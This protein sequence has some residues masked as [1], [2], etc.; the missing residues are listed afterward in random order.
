VVLLNVSS[1]ALRGRVSPRDPIERP[2]LWKSEGTVRLEA[3]TN[4]GADGNDR[5]G[6]TFFNTANDAA[7][8]TTFFGNIGPRT[9]TATWQVRTLGGT[10]TPNPDASANLSGILGET[11][12]TLGRSAQSPESCTG[13]G[14][15]FPFWPFVQL[16][17]TLPSLTTEQLDL[18]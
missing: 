5:V 14:S 13:E 6:L 18:H 8:R 11:T 10:M 17:Q 16:R 12:C 4:V 7:V 1:T 2:I 3:R 9:A 15:F